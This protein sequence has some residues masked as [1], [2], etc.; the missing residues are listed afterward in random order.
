MI[1]SKKVNEAAG[2]MLACVQN[3]L[4]PNWYLGA[5]SPDDEVDDYRV[6]LYEHARSDRKEIE[7][8]TEETTDEDGHVHRRHRVDHGIIVRAP[9]PVHPERL[10]MILAGP[11]GLGTAAACLAATRSPLIHDIKERLPGSV[12][13]ADKSQPFWVLVRGEASKSDG[14]LDE[15]GVTILR[16]GGYEK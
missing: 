13:L 10:V 4:L 8:E 16:A 7:G 11:H 3:G 12:D 2:E 6:R 14:L 5:E 9:H 15:E 1:G